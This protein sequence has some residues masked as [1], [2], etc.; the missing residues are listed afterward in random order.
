[1]PGGEDILAQIAYCHYELKQY[2]VAIRAYEKVMPLLDEEGQAYAHYW[3]ADSLEQLGN[4]ED[5]AAAFLRIPY[6][7]PKEGQLSVTAQ[8]KAAGVYEQMGND[9]AAVRIYEK[10]VAS[11]GANSQWGGEA[12][13]RLRR[14]RERTHGES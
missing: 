7:Y 3:I 11:H 9:E 6:L 2:D 12:S 8:L 13:K 14:I 1:V 10:V 5:A 4:Y